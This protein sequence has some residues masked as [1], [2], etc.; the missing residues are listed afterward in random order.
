MQH[1]QLAL[2]NRLGKILLYNSAQPQLTQ[3]MLQKLNELG[4]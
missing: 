1:L 3:P 2:L 4:Y